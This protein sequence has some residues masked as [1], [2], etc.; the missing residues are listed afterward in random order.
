MK[1]IALLYTL[2]LF[3]FLHPGLIVSS[4][5]IEK[6][7]RKEKSAPVLVL[8]PMHE[9]CE[10]RATNYFEQTLNTYA[11]CIEVSSDESWLVND[12][13]NIRTHG[14]KLCKQVREDEHFKNGNFSIVSFSYGG[15][16]ARYLIEY[17]S[18]PNPIRNVVTMGSPLNG[19]SAVSHMPRDTFLGSMVDWVID[20]LIYLDVFERVFE[21]ADYWREPEDEEGYL[22]HSRFLA[23]ANNEINYNETRKEAWTHLNK[24][25]FVKWDHDETIIPAESAWWGQ[26]DENFHVLD[27]QHT[28]LYKKDL[29][30]IRQLEETHKSQ[31]L[32]LPGDHMQFNYT[33]I[34]EWVLPVL[35]A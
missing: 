29:I 33:Q 11:R 20:K 28:N 2:V 23:E 30:G 12:L 4:M 35:R 22:A 15:M 8:Y 3:T 13:Y 16:M 25:L 1:V 27:R 10:F 24:A 9:E 31:Y 26:F 34:N 6:T 32:E 18:F 21:P 17:C 19:V 14:E 7:W 5:S